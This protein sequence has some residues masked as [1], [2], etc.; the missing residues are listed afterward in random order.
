[1]AE[2]SLRELRNHGGRVIERVSAGEEITITKDGAPVARLTP[3]PKQRLS[4]R[5]LVDRRRSLP[6]VDPVAL[7]ADLDGTLDS[8]L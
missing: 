5:T 4:T 7:R 1:M 3:L 2:A 8:R 6:R